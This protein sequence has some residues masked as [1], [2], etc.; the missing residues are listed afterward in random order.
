MKKNG[1]LQKYTM[2]SLPFCL[3][4]FYGTGVPSAIVKDMHFQV[5]V[6]SQKTLVKAPG[7]KILFTLLHK[8][9]A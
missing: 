1:K 3:L 2:Q 9:H 6:V 5:I 7:R 4:L 8:L